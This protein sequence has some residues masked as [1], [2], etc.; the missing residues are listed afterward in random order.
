MTDQLREQFP[1]DYDHNDMYSVYCPCCN[2]NDGI[3]YHAAYE[4]LSAEVERPREAALETDCPA[5]LSGL[6]ILVRQCLSEGRCRCNLGAALQP[7]EE[8]T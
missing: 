4:A 3:D 2:N 7:T 1:C 8:T 6:T 5:P